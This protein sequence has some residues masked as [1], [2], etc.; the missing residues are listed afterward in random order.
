MSSFLGVTL[1]L[2]LGLV[3]E[4][5]DRVLRGVFPWLD[6]VFTISLGSDGLSDDDLSGFPADCPSIMLR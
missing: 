6:L 3:A 4:I 1:S 2:V 5:E